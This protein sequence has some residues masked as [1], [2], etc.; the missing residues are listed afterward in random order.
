MNV[1]KEFKGSKKG[2]KDKK[3]KRVFAFFVLLAFSASPLA[4]RVQ[5]ARAS[6]SFTA[7]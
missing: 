2:K 7:G 3:T 4:A 5:N 1:V 6:A